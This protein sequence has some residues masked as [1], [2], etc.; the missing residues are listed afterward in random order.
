MLIFMLNERKSE[1][2]AGGHNTQEPCTHVVWDG[3]HVLGVFGA[4]PASF[5]LCHTSTV[6]RL[7]LR[8]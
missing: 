1:K 4:G 6:E 5:L 2:A 8:V 3:R 7:D